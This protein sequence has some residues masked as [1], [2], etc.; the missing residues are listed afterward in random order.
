MEH[1]DSLSQ[2]AGSLPPPP[3]PPPPALRNRQPPLFQTA[4]TRDISPTLTKRL[5]ALKWRGR[6]S[7]TPTY[8][9][10]VAG[11][12]LRVEQRLDSERVGMD[13]GGYIWDAAI[14]LCKYVERRFGPNG[15][16]G[17]RV[18]ELGAGTGLV[19]LCCAALGADV[20]ITDVG[21]VLELAGR[22]CQANAAVLEGVGSIRVCEYWWG[23]PAKLLQPP[24]DLIVASECI[25]PRLYP[26]EPF[27]AA[28]G[29]WT[30]PASRTLVAYEHRLWHE[31]DPAARF[32]KQCHNAGLVVNVIPDDAMHPDYVAPD[33]WFWEITR[34]RDPATLASFANSHGL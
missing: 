3:P 5:C 20:T 13:T 10:E 30:G 24:F 25:V 18:L 22:N 19:G 6:P 17:H 21:S 26:I 14:A 28:L 1:P 34:P 27:V 7:A 12:T 9:L 33:I 4:A 11:R 16:R 31:F 29:A 15:L 32:I 2:G 8:F 23:L